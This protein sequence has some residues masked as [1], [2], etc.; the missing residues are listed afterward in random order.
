MS[1]FNRRNGAIKLYLFQ[2]LWKR[3]GMDRRTAMTWENKSLQ[4]SERRAEVLRGA[5][6]DVSRELLLRV[7]EQYKWDFELFQYDFDRTLALA[8]Y[9]PRP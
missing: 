7:F 1:S 4:D 2:Y 8:G 9:E 5:Y 6:A 3:T